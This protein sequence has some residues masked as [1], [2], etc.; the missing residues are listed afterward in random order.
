MGESA[1]VERRERRVVDEGPRAEE[2]KL[3]SD[4]F[5]VT[6]RAQVTAIEDVI[7]GDH[8]ALAEVEALLEK[9]GRNGWSWS[10]AYEVEQR[11]CELYPP[12]LLSVELERR[13]VEAQGVLKPALAGWYQQR[14]EATNDPEIRRSLLARLVNDLQWR[15]TVEEVKRGYSKELARKTGALFLGV[16]ACFTLLLLA[17]VVVG[18]LEHGPGYRVHS[19]LWFLIASTAGAW[20][21]AFSTLIGLNTQL[22]D[23]TLDALKLKRHWSLLLGRVAVGTGAALVLYFMMHAQ[24]LQGAMFPDFTETDSTDL[25]RL[26][27]WCF[28]AGFSEKLV[29]D[30]LARTGNQLRE[31][32]PSTVVAADS[33]PARPVKPATPT[34]APTPAT[35]NA[36][37]ESAQHTAA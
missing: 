2:I 23:V 27:I 3:L 9:A 26:V 13:L 34:P 1:A 5:L 14:S 8:P 37:P 28:I 32:L 31:A 21:A 4:Q 11:L 16:S 35:T 30:L 17:S 18:A 12:E 22:S 7:Q 36:E 19:T 15:Y 25:A 20:G 6:L 24:L 33:P 29:P 10:D